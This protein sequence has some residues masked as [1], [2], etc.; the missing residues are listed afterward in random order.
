MLNGSN[1]FLRSLAISRSTAFTFRL[2]PAHHQM[3]SSSIVSPRFL[4]VSK[5]LNP[6][7]GV[8]WVGGGSHQLLTGSR[9]RVE[10]V[11][12]ITI[13]KST[14]DGARV[15]DAQWFGLQMLM[16][17]NLNSCL[18][19]SPSWS[20]FVPVFWNVPFHLFISF[21]PKGSSQRKLKPQ[22]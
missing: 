17:T 6:A 1:D 16:F 10:S 2:C 15:A 12:E 11:V 13:S 19:P 8:G 5:S 7:V 18:G 22:R 3:S 21:L 4:R 9:L 20:S 14:G